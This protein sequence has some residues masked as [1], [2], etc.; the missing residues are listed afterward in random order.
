MKHINVLQNEGL[1]KRENRVHSVFAGSKPTTAPM[2]HSSALA[3]RK[4]S[5]NVHRDTSTS[6][7]RKKY[8]MSQTSTQKELLVTKKDIKFVTVNM[9][10]MNLTT[11]NLSFNKILYIPDEVCS[12][13]SL[14][15]LR[16]DHNNI[17][18][19]PENLG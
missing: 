12:L 9:L 1:M 5:I 6:V 13:H 17:K 14:A 3:E 8:Q 10:N 15:S 2:A 4:N 16:I 11:V 7:V 18:H 19:L